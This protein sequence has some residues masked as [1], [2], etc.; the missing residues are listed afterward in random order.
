MKNKI[1]AILMVIALAVV[2]SSCF[3]SRSKYGCP[4]NPQYSSRFRG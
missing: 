1:Y 2:F 3:S 4:A